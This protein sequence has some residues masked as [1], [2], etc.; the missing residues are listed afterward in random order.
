MDFARIILVLRVTC[1]NRKLQPLYAFFSNEYVT[2]ECENS[3]TSIFREIET[4]AE[5]WDA[6][7]RNVHRSVKEGGLKCTCKSR[8]TNGVLSQYRTRVRGHCP[9]SEP[10][11]F[12][13]ISPIGVAGVRRL[14]ELTIF[15]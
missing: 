13:T 6:F 3:M 8:Q 15:L 10:R 14:G 7:E 1:T 11:K 12:G 2:K 5:G 9:N 4:A